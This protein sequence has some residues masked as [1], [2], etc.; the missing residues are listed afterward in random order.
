MSVRKN[1]INANFCNDHAGYWLTSKEQTN[2]NRNNLKKEAGVGKQSPL[3][4][5][6]IR[7][8]GIIGLSL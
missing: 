3:S 2:V 5:V 1:K 4:I 8:M 6:P 7:L